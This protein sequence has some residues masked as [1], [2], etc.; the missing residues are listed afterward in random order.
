MIDP[1]P[2]YELVASFFTLTGAGFAEEPRH[3][4]VDRCRAAAAARFTGIGL[5]VDDL[6]R[7]LASGLD[8][9][10]MQAVLADAGLRVVEIEFLG[11]WALEADPVEVERLL[12]RIEAAA[13]AALDTVDAPRTAA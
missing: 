7:T 6:P 4:F 1:S 9:R 10:G 11:G 3:A 13:S 12:G 8:T 2:G 5:H